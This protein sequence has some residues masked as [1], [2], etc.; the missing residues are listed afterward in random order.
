M[1]I[2][3]SLKTS[4]LFLFFFFKALC[5]S[6]A[7]AGCSLNV[8]FKCSALTKLLFWWDF[9]DSFLFIYDFAPS[10]H[11]HD[12]ASPYL[13]SSS[14]VLLMALSRDFALEN[15]AF[16]WLFLGMFFHSQI[17]SISNKFKTIL[18]FN[19]KD[20]AYEALPSWLS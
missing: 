2:V 7:Y 5:G 4:Q 10:V 16:S 18:F 19:H 15:P 11:N 17:S 13:S 9:S 3:C 12:C 1:L 20:L 6:F 14:Q 8:C